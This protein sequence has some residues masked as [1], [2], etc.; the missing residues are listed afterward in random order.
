MLVNAIAI[1]EVWGVVQI[2]QSASLVEV[3][4]LTLEPNLPILPVLG[5]RKLAAEIVSVCVYLPL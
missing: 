4:F 3:F 1:Y 5:I 2:D